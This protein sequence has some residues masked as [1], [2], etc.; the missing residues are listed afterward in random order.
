MVELGPD[1]SELSVP[2]AY[3]VARDWFDRVC[4]DRAL[5]HVGYKLS[6][7]NAADQAIVGA[8]APAVGRLF[9]ESVLPSGTTLDLQLANAPA[10]EPEVVFRTR[11]PLD[12]GMSDEELADAIEL[13][14]G[15][16]V[17]VS[18]VLDWWPMGGAPRM[19]LSS[20]VADN[21]VAG[22]VVVGSSWSTLTPTEIAGI[23]VT[24]LAADGG[25]AKGVAERVM[26]S[27][28]NSLR[29]LI[30]VLAVQGEAIP[31]GMV[32]SSG[33]LMPPQRVQAGRYVADFDLLGRAEV[34]FA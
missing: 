17:P 10:L 26:G 4:R 19:T 11:L 32:V 33:T 22:C 6:M 12:S 34:T 31:E 30:D 28:L 13:A 1:L 2:A 25:Q 5:E 27:P 24:V 9:D 29:W 3:A 20:A 21:A 7:T 18:R 23:G 15:I 8:H 14:A 16:E